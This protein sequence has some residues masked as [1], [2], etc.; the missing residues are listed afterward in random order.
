MI[1]TAVDMWCEH[2][3]IC[4]TCTDFWETN[5]DLCSI[6][7]EYLRVAGNELKKKYE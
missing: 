5:Q 6:G 7:E 4:D 1:M 3:D 2:V